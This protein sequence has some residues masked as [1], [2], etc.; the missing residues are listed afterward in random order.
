MAGGTDFFAAVARNPYAP[1]VVAVGT[2]AGAAVGFYVEYHVNEYY[3]KDRLRKFDEFLALEREVAARKAEAEA[4]T[5]SS[6][7]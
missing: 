7:R 3:K 4:A 2:L 1:A 5:S 6:K